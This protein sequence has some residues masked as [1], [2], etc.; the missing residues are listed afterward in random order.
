MIC[1]KCKIDKEESLFPKDKTR[2]SGYKSFCKNCCSE[3]RKSR[4][5]DRTTSE[6]NKKYWIKNKN[7][8]SIRYYTRNYR[9][10]QL[11]RY[12]LKK[13][14]ILEK[15]KS[16]LKTPQGRFKSCSKE[17]KRRA[18]KLQATPPWLTK[19]HLAQIDYLYWLSNDLQITSGQ[20]YHV[21]HIVPLQG[22]KVC[23]LHVPWNLQILPA[24]N[25]LSKGNKHE[26]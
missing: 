18:R 14:E 25:N 15:Q 7:E 24:K 8:L 13:D 17:A 4:S 16:Y 26:Y 6:Y 22:K 11:S 5:G 23:G 3:S 9:E 12:Y 1:S 2:K 21:D 20:K 19:E 10:A